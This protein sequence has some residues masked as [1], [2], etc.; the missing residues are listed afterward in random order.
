MSAL[1]RLE[2]RDARWREFVSASDGALPFHEPE[3]ALL[4]AECYG[5]QA[6]ALALEEDGAIQAGLPVLEVRG[7]LGG[8]RWVSLPFTDHC[9]PLAAAP[10]VQVRLA[11][12][13]DEA[14]KEAGVGRLD[15][16][17]ELSGAGAQ[18]WLAGVTHTLE[19]DPDPARV[20]PTFHPSQVQ[21]SV[22]KAEQ[23]P[24]VLRR[25]ETETDLTE[26]F[27]RLHL[28]SRRRQGVPIQPRRFFRLLWRRVLEPGLGFLTLAYDGGTPVAGAVFLAANGTVT[29]K[30]G[31]S[32]Q[33]ALRL[34]P[35]HLV[36]WDAI[37]WGCDNGYTSFDF[38]R[39]ELEN[40]GLREFKSRWGAKEE[41]LRYSAVAADAPEPAQ[42][43]AART[44]GTVIRRSPAWVCRGLG[45]ALYKYA[46]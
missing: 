46:A 32:D 13:L 1:A 15:L 21:R 38:G 45:E 27:Y 4:L 24:I 19:L 34:R 29:Y 18:S 37:R 10:D 8:R 22:R 33:R 23:G 12:G 6:F 41:P 17:A 31:A 11:E 7:L 26:A 20:F 2:L 42:G 39:T 40:S 36:F 43:R 35:N 28:D 16:H 3:W 9:P 5:F 14:R 25:A 30:Y 44:L